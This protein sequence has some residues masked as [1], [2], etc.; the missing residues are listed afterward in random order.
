MAKKNKNPQVE[1]PIEFTSNME[2]SQPDDQLLLSDEVLLNTEEDASPIDAPP[3]LLSENSDEDDAYGAGVWYSNKKI[4][5][6]WS[7]DQNRNS[8]AAISGIGWR[9][10]DTKNDSST[11]SLTMLCAHAKDRNRN[12][13]VKLDKKRIVEIYVW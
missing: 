5:S 1:P 11:V 12:V 10:I 9:K 3:E 7:I 2:D 6:L 4:T 8:W 13:R